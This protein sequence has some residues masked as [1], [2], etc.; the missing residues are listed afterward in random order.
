MSLAS[1]TD[2]PSDGGTR[3][4]T[5]H[6]P[7]ALVDELEQRIR[8]LHEGEERDFGEFGRL[9]WLILVVVALILPILL[10]IRFAP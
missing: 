7:D 9:D 4:G 3:D 8:E 10:V 6:R 2:S 1:D 5:G